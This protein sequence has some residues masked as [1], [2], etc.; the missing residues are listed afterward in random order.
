MTASLSRDLRTRRFWWRFATSFFSS[1]GVIAAVLQGFDVLEPDRVSRSDVPLI[2]MIVLVSVIFAAVKSWPRP[3]QQHFPISHTEVRIIEG[4]LFEQ[5]TD[6]VIGM[7]DTFDTEVPHIIRSDGV[8]GQFLE[9]V[10]AHDRAALDAALSAALDGIQPVGTITKEGK[11]EKYRIGTI[12]AIRQNRRHFFCVAYSEM[13]ER[14]EARATIDGL[15]RSLDNLWREV[16]ARSNGAPLSIPVIGGGQ[17]RLASVLPAQDSIRFIVLSFVFA[18]RLE[19]VCDRLDVVV[20]KQ[21]A[22]ALDMLELQAFLRSLS[23]S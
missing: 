1:V 18:S 16:R 5:P 17:A 2:P 7:C 23:P 14:N 12:A 11:Q 10:F 4:D 15:W 6:L 3:I 22:P 20:R 13:N 21:D 9:R 19:R 8:Q